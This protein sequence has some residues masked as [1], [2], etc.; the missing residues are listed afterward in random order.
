[1]ELSGEA[2]VFGQERALKF[3]G[4][5]H[6]AQKVDQVS[7]TCIPQ[8]AGDASM[9]VFQAHPYNGLSLKQRVEFSDGVTTIVGRNG[10]GKSRLLQ[11][12]K[13]KHF[14]IELPSGPLDNEQRILML[15]S[16]QLVPQLGQSLDRQTIESGRQVAIELYEKFRERFSMDLQATVDQLGNFDGMQQ[17][18]NNVSSRALALAAIKA[19]TTLDKDVQ[20]LSSDDI[21]QFFVNS[22][23]FALGTLS[24]TAEF[25]E[26][27]SLV[28]ENKYR[29]YRKTLGESRECWPE[30]EFVQRIGR[31]P[32]DVLNSYLTRVLDGK[33]QF[34]SPSNPYDK[35]LPFTA[36]LVRAD[37]TPVT[38]NNLSSGEKTLL[39]LALSV[40]RVCWRKA[41]E[42]PQLILLDEPDST[43]HP[44]MLPSF[45]NALREISTELKCPIIFSTHSPTTVALFDQDSIYSVS[46]EEITKKSRDEAIAELL[47]GIDQISIQPTNRRHVYVESFKD[48]GVYE[49]MTR[50]LRLWKLL[51]APGI[52][53]AFLTSG[54][55]AN[56]TTLRDALKSTLGVEGADADKVVSVV[57]G[58]SNCDQVRQTVRQLVE[59]DHATV[60]GIIDW[61]SKNKPDRHL[62]VLGAG[63]FY[64]IENAVLNPLTLGLYLVSQ[65]RMQVDITNF[66][67]S[68]EFVPARALA[69]PDLWQGIADGV[70]R[71]V[72]KKENVKHDIPC[73]F[74]RGTV[75]QFDSE[76]VHLGRHQ[77]EPKIC[78]AYRF[79]NGLRLKNAMMREVVEYAI[80]PSEGASLPSVFVEVFT[81]VQR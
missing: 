41:T 72:L 18:R 69:N 48:V 32:W 36:E 25:V 79:L 23:S 12:I 55:K 58:Q 1:M 9:I 43:L 49:E 74:A 56:E 62:H 68:P 78:E 70:T 73:S 59:S 67:L 26:H 39:W 6:L 5:A 28:E 7:N 53:L 61:D 2:T 44:Q 57:N 52:S 13:A 45:L 33:Y 22:H 76:Y 75:V 51:P 35:D 40:Y 16:A 54:P 50:L 24:V 77:L 4:T 10:A 21:K 14:R 71:A 29:N 20:K 37:G 19:A 15:D 17:R 65:H 42:S 47:V 63:V 27:A 66:G 38:P 31:P 64:S 60:H 81:A 46:E 30:E 11:G 3:G 80:L 34:T 8:P